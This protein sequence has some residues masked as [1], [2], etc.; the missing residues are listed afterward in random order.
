MPRLDPKA[1]ARFQHIRP[2]RTRTFARPLNGPLTLEA[3]ME[4]VAA[5]YAAGVPGNAPTH[6]DGTLMVARWTVPMADYPRNR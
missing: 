2:V 3:Q 1:A 4:F 6:S 5:A